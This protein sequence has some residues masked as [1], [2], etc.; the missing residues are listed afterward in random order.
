MTRQ[1]DGV[2]LRNAGFDGIPI[3]A[4][5]SYD[6]SLFARHLYTGNRWGPNGGSLLPPPADG[7]R[8]PLIARLEN[9]R[10]ELLGETVLEVPKTE[11]TQF[12]ERPR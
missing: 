5:E 9:S 3:K 4:G 11:W 10:G 12:H 1:G 7:K 8:P 2:G 6:V